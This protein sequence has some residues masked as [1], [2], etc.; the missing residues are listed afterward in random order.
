MATSAAG[1]AHLTRR[2][3]PFTTTIFATMSELALATKSVNLGQGFPDTDGPE[4]LREIAVEAIREGRNQYPPSQGIPELRQ[5]VATHQRDWYGI[6]L[7]PDTDI[8]V[9]VGAT[10]AIAA[11][12]LALCEPG[13]EVVMFEPTYDS[14]AADASMAGAVPRLV[15]LHPPD[16]HFDPGELAAAIGPRTKMLLLNSPHNPTGKVFTPDELGQVAALCRA[17]DILAVTDEVYEHLVFEGSHIP[18]ST[19]PGMRDR[20][21]TISSGGK[22]FSFTGW[23]VGWVTGTSALVTAVR[24]TK[25][26]LTYTSPAPLQLAIARGLAFA[27]PALHQLSLELRARRDQLCEGLAALGYDVFRPAATYFAT[28]DITPV[29]P[30]LRAMDFCLALPERCGVVAIPSSAFYDPADADAGRT[31]VRW[32]FCKRADVL[33]D[34]LARLA[35]WG[36]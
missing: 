19:L 24:T 25:Q 10:E 8:L 20:T 27:P 23:K 31:L 14:Y 33:S 17:H 32:A 35:S 1:D 21:L 5:A 29:A 36:P 11:T 7:D 15:R 12:F 30:G 6:E 16:W 28:T 13:D 18:L 34:A 3:Q 9:T 4:E 2:L 22:T 26:F